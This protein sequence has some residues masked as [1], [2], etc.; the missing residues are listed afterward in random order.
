MRVRIEFKIR[1]AFRLVEDLWLSVWLDF[2]HPYSD[3]AD[4]GCSDF[5]GSG[6]EKPS[7]SGGRGGRSRVRCQFPQP[8]FFLF[9]FCSSSLIS[10]VSVA[11]RP[12][13][14]LRNYHFFPPI[15]VFKQ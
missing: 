6:V 15:A 3:R 14:L 8:T 9:F 11:P 12:P 5:D 7:W 10:Y 2:D 13:G 1:C 4:S